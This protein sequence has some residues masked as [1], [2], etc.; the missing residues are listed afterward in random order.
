MA[1]PKKKTNKVDITASGSLTGRGRFEGKGTLTLSLSDAVKA[2]LRVE[3]E[4]GRTRL[5]LSNAVG[6]RIRKSKTLRLTG[7]LSK[8]LNRRG[9][10]GKVALSLNLPRGIDWSVSH[11][12]K[13]GSNYTSM[14][15]TIR[16]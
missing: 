10:E 8:E 3:T 16:F 5:T 12:F 6:L 2:G 4:N 1:S 9:L 14:K 11:E 13:P 7:T 15:L